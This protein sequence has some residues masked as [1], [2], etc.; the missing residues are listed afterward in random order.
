[1]SGWFRSNANGYKL[2]DSR[3]ESSTIRVVPQRRVEVGA[4]AGIHQLIERLA[5][6]G[7]A[8]GVISSYLTEI[9]NLSDRILVMQSGWVVE[10]FTPEAATEK[11]VMS[12]AVHGSAAGFARRSQ[13]AEVNRAGLWP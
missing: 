10:E 9:M 1:M 8:I 11:K 13:S 6:Q 12:A 2:M 7:M 5:D 3:C 4:I